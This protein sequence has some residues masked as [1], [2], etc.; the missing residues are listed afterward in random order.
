MSD[1]IFYADRLIRLVI[2]K[3]LDQLPAQRCTV[4]TPTG[5]YRPLFVESP[6]IYTFIQAA[7]MKASNSRKAIVA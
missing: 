5:A 7:L 6:C 4:I 2:E 3:G 1:F